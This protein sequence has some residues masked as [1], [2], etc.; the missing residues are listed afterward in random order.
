MRET[1][2]LPKWRSDCLSI[3]VCKEEVEPA[4]FSSIS[5]RSWGTKLLRVIC[6]SGGYTQFGYNGNIRNLADSDSLAVIE[7]DLSP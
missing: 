4:C 5:Y 3:S 1:T 7:K 6:V 2:R